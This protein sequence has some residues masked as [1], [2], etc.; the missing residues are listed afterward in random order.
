MDD[1]RPDSNQTLLLLDEAT[2]G[3]Q[4]A[5]GQL[6]KRHLPRVKATV[7]CRIDR[8]VR[9][10]LDPSD[11][12][13]ETQLEVTR[14]FEEFLAAR[15]MPFHLWLKRATHQQILKAER[16]HLQTA[17]RA[18]DREVPLPDRTSLHL[19]AGLAA[20]RHSPVSQATAKELARSVRR[21]LA[22]LSEMDREIIM[23]RNFEGLSNGEAACLLAISPEAAKKRYTR[24][25]VRLQKLLR[26]EGLT[27]GQP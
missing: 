9:A 12:V 1:V 14:R 10:R 7:A 2:A 26:D 8:R 16:R 6:L 17:K 24:S 15:P 19:V 22:Q 23:L 25:L 4:Q 13:Q 20:G 21:T 27:G 5:L 3:N 11:V 18:V